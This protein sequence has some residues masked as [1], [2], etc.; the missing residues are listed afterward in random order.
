MPRKP[1]AAAD[2]LTGTDR[3]RFLELQRQATELALEAAKLRYK[4]W[5]IFYTA[6][7]RTPRK[8][9]PPQAS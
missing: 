9:R 7:G 8:P 5:D 6:T 1:F 3:E 4:A 2:L